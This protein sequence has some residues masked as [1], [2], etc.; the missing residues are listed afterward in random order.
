MENIA[1]KLPLVGW[2][3]HYKTNHIPYYFTK[4]R[5][6]PPLFGLHF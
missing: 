1:V 2:K 5:M 4:G 6:V 3:K